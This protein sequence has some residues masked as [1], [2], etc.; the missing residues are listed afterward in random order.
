[1]EV[2]INFQDKASEVRPLD[3]PTWLLLGLMDLGVNVHLRGG[4]ISTS[5]PD[6]IDKWFLP[7]Y[8]NKWLILLSLYSFTALI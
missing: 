5:W 2:P 8:A 7:F 6:Y 1:M 4:F 3:I